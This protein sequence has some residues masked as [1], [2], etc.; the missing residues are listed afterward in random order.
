MSLLGRLTETIATKV[1]ALLDRFDEPGEALDYAYQLELEQLLRVRRAVMD[2]ASSQKHLEVQVEQLRQAASGLEARARKELSTGRE[3]N[4][5]EALARRTVI[6]RG[7][8]SIVTQAE[9]IAGDEHQFVRA[10]DRLE[11]KVNA[12]AA[13]KGAMKARYV[14]TGSRADIDH[15]VAE[16][17]D[18]MRD[19]DSAVR[20][21][22][23]RVAEVNSRTAAIDR[24]L[25]S[26]ALYDFAQSPLP[27][28]AEL[29]WVRGS[30]DV[31]RELARIRR[32]L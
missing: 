22:E 27:I 19:I 24:L 9:T 1:N 31:E 10:A 6:E 16:L 26:G 17:H 18:E 2:V 30:D 13:R 11:D 21:A 8:A 4:A 29:G 32:S 12:L 15:V 5:R 28:E 20:R 14:A 23:T 3:D 25:A 7:L